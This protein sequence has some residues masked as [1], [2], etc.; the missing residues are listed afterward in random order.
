MKKAKYFEFITRT[1][2]WMIVQKPSDE[3]YKAD[4]AD[5]EVT[6]IDVIKAIKHK[7]KIDW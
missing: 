7:F 2:H 3:M 1:L 6:P 5:S 4:E